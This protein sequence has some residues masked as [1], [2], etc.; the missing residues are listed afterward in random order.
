[1]L[2]VLALFAI[3]DFN[4]QREMEQLRLE[5]DS[6][7]IEIERRVNTLGLELK[8]NE[9]ESAPANQVP[10]EVM[11]ITVPDPSTGALVPLSE[12]IG[13]MS[14]DECRSQLKACFSSF[15]HQ[16]RYYLELLSGL[17]LRM[18]F[19]S[20]DEMLA[21]DC[22]DRRGVWSNGECLCPEP[23]SWYAEETRE[24]CVTDPVV[25]EHRLNLCFDSGGEFSCLGGC[26]CSPGQ[27]LSEDQCAGRPVAVE[28]VD[29]AEARTA[30]LEVRVR[31]LEER[32]SELEA[33]LAVDGRER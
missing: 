31:F 15:A 13:Q 16:E 33:R 30:V 26:L 18:G 22:R 20:S 29:G 2:T 28:V 1:M 6:R 17:A 9:L 12:V 4:R 3:S 10:D 24:C 11:R 23:Y 19:G 7:I 27:E 5:H 32:V 14:A 25:Y 21:V 8:A